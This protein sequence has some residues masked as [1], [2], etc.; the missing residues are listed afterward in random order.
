MIHSDMDNAGSREREW[1]EIWREKEGRR[2]WER[3]GGRETDKERVGETC[4]EE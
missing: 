4:E 3:V 2:G 1:V